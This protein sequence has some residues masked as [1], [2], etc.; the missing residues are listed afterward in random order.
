MPASGI[1]NKNQNEIISF[2]EIYRI[3]NV[4]VNLGIKKVRL[5]G[6]EP[7]VRKDLVLLIKKLKNIT[8]LR[9]LC[10][11]TNGKPH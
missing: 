1:L 3:V 9:E 4:A 7:L 6:G 2:E 11:T 5:T 10:L 8:G